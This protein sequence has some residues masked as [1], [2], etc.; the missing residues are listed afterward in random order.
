MLDLDPDPDQ[1]P[2]PY[3]INTDPQSWSTDHNKN[4]P[5]GSASPSLK[6]SGDPKLL[7][8]RM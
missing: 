8:E 2:D 6:T 1:D 7:A 5:N 4:S 3:Q